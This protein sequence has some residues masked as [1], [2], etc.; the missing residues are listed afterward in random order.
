M[1]G[2]GVLRPGLLNGEVVTAHS[3]V[4][5]R[6]RTTGQ[7]ALLG[8]RQRHI[9]LNGVKA[10][11]EIEIIKAHI[12]IFLVKKKSDS[13]AQGNTLCRAEPKLLSLPF[14]P[15]LIR[16]MHRALMT[17]YFPQCGEGQGRVSAQPPASLIID[18]GD[19]PNKGNC[20]SRA[21]EN[22]R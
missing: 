2:S 20:Q 10:R 14:L 6:S 16:L 22:G 5:R 1:F 4:R 13:E 3:A 17:G 18:G 7:P 8:P 19:A 9:S 12:C 15:L 21:A 11:E